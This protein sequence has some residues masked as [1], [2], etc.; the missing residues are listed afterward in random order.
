MGH[1]VILSGK[2]FLDGSQY[3]GFLYFRPTFQVKVRFSPEIISA[4]GGFWNGYFIFVEC[5][6]SGSA[7]SSFSLCRPS[8]E[9]GNAM[10]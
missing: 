9:M 6:Q 2:P 4:R 5:W 10:G 7:S 8:N 3:G 1:S